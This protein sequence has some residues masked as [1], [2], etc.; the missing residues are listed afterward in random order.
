[1]HI[2]VAL[3]APF[4]WGKAS[5]AGIDKGV[6]EILLNLAVCVLVRDEEGDACVEAFQR[7]GEAGAV[8]VVDY[9]VGDVWG[10]FGRLGAREDG[11]LMVSWAN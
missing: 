5:D 2:R 6:D 4:A 9:L 1:V 11:N 3:D 8:V 7:F 10:G